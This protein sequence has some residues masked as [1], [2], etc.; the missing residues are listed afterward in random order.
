[1]D[2]VHDDE[3]VLAEGVVGEHLHA[4]SAKGWVI[5]PARCIV[6]FDDVVSSRIE[7]R[8]VGLYSLLSGLKEHVPGDVRIN[9][10]LECP[11]I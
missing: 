8:Q 6:Y 4:W 10:I 11:V 7:E 5:R 3:A 9:A 1:M 2:G